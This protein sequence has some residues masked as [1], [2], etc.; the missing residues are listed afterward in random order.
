MVIA[1]AEAL[2]NRMRIASASPRNDRLFSFYQLNLVSVG[3]FDE[4]DYRSA[5]LHGARRSCDFAA[6]PGNFFARTINIGDTEC[7]VAV[8][9]SQVVFMDSPVVREFQEG[10][11][12]QIATQENQ[13]EFAARIVGSLVKFKVQHLS[14][15]FYGFFEICYPDHGV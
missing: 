3:I 11:G 12:V 2:S 13:R 15:K 7:H 14:V 10:F 6:A 5:M 8:S 9:G 4:G 1:R